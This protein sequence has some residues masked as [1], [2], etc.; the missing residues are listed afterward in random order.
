MPGGSFVHFAMNAAIARGTAS[1]QP[2]KRE[3]VILI[4]G[5]GWILGRRVEPQWRHREF[6][7]E[8]L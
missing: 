8:G 1:E 3:D 7:V 6:I 4:D 5:R 2:L